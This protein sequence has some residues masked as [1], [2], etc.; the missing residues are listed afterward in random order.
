L[1]RQF[2]AARHRFCTDEGVVVNKLPIPAIALAEVDG[3]ELLDYMQRP[4]S[5]RVALAY[6][7][8]VLIIQGLRAAY[9]C[10]AK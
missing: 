1:Q 4:D 8:D 9:P 10:P 7:E 5:H 2:Q 6:I 3:N